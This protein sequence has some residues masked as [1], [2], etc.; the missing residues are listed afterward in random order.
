MSEIRWCDAGSHPF[1]YGRDNDERE[2]AETRERNG[3][4]TRIDV[5]GPCFRKGESGIATALVSSVA[6]MTDAG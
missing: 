4:R 1:P 5:C 2:F 3:R 6:D